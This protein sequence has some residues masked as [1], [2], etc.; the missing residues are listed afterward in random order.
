MTNAYNQEFKNDFSR[1]GYCIID[2]KKLF[3]SDLMSIKKELDKTTDESWTYV[4]KY[5]DFEADLLSSTELKVI[6]K[7]KKA[8]YRNNSEGKLAYFFKR[9]TTDHGLTSVPIAQAFLQAQG[10]MDSPAIRRLLEFVTGRDINDMS[11][12]YI[13]KF[14]IGDFLGIHKDGG[15]N[16]GVALNLSKD[17]ITTNGGNTHIVDDE[18]NIID[19]L[20]PCFGKLLVFDSMKENVPHFVST[21]TS[22]NNNARMSIIARYN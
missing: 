19:S 15:N 7:H 14:E 4:V 11:Q 8:A 22:T 9:I 2:V 13:N 10:L 21:V 18:M 5:D 12:I 20:S 1:K 17:W 16:I 6:E 3:S